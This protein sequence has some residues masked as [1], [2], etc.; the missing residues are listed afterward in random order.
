MSASSMEFELGS[1]HEFE[2]E[3]EFEGEFEREGEYE[4]E[5]EFEQEQFFGGLA[6]LVRRGLQSPTLRRLGLSAARAA[7]GGMGRMLSEHEFEGEGEFEFEFAH[8]HEFETN[9][10]RRVYPDAMM[11]HFAH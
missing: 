5:G 8:E 7:M 3:S 1:F 11:E 4:F 9:P 2:G 6:K 10:I